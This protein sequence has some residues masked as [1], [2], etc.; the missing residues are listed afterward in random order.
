MANETILIVDDEKNI[1]DLYDQ[2]LQDEGY[3][4]FLAQNGKECLEIIKNEELDLIVLDIRMPKMDGLE[5]I[6]NIIDIN[7]KIPVI[8][9]SAYSNYKDDFMSWA[10]E[11]YVVK[12]YN[13]D[14]LKKTIKNVL[15]KKKTSS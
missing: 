13:L 1:L 6:G 12:S 3:S 7:N 2:E 4:T 11:A 15:K 9:N 10:A 5:A 8:I 14:E